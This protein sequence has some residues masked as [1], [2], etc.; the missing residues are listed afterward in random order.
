MNRLLFLLMQNTHWLD[1]PACQLV[2]LTNENVCGIFYS[3][4]IATK[5]TVVQVKLC[6]CYSLSDSAFNTASEGM[7][8]GYIWKHLI[9]CY[10]TRMRSEVQ[11]LHSFFSCLW[12]G[13]Q[14]HRCAKRSMT[15]SPAIVNGSLYPFVVGCFRSSLGCMPCLAKRGICRSKLRP[16]VC[17]FSPSRY[18]VPRWVLMQ[19]RALLPSVHRCWWWSSGMPVD[20]FLQ[21]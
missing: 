19:T 13:R 16:A 3:D 4:R 20:L 8:K 17:A 7:W 14:T 9:D 11:T 21:G 5:F 1:W 10:V 12:H 6:F 18:S 2:R 15:G